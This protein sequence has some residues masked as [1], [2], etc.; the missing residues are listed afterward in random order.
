MRQEMGDQP[1]EKTDRYRTKCFINEEERIQAH[2]RAVF[3]SIGKTEQR[4]D[5]YRRK[6]KLQAQDLDKKL[7]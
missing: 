4:E 5:L 2:M 3:K 1:E 7:Y 6:W